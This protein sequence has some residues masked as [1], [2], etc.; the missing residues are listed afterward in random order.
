MDLTQLDN[1]LKLRKYS[2]ETRKNYT[3]TVEKFLKSNQSLR[4]FMLNYSDKSRSTVRSIYFALKFYYEKVLNEIFSEKLPLAK[5]S[6]KLPIVLS[7]EEIQKILSSTNNLKHKLILSFLYYAGLRLDEARNLKWPDLDFDRKIIHLKTAKGEK[8]RIIFLHD[9]LIAQLKFYKAND[10]QLLFLSNLKRKYNKR[11]IELIV[12]TAAA[13][14]RINKKVTPHTLRH[15]FATH[16]LEAGVDIRYIQ[17]LLGHKDLK[18]TQVY[19]HVADRD[20]KNLA[21]LI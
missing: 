11:S 16:L 4:D 5:K 10:S 21:S 6:Q 9:N 14:S 7:R 1:E 19:T 17:Q 15:S 12:K 8:E 2:V 13:N 3:Q 20:I 18:T